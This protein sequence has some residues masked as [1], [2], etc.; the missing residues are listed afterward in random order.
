[1][2]DQVLGDF[3]KLL[4]SVCDKDKVDPVTFDKEM[5]VITPEELRRFGIACRAHNTE[6]C[7]VICESGVF[8]RQDGLDRQHGNEMAAAI[9]RMVQEKVKP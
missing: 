6:E 9:R 5:I 1:M 8:K 7:A 3:I 4:R 2:T